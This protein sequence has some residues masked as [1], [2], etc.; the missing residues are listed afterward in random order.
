[1]RK[2]FSISP[3]FGIL[4]MLLLFSCAPKVSVV[5]CTSQ[6]YYPG[7]QEEKPFQEIIIEI[8][9]LEES[10]QL[11]SLQYGNQTL[12]LRGKETTYRAKAEGTSFS[13]NATLHFSKKNKQH[14]VQ[15]D[16]ISKLEALYLP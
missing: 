15:I 5:S 10:V 7:R 1:M 16:S 9:E 14:S 11:D 8:N 6:E 4:S 13:N 3:I 2:R 12:I